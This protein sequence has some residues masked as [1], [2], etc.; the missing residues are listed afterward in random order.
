MPYKCLN[1]NCTNP[2][3]DKVF[4]HT[5][6]L[7]EF[8]SP[9]EYDTLESAACPFCRSKAYIE[10]EAVKPESGMEL[11]DII[12]L[13]EC[14]P[15]DVDTYLAQDYVVLQTWQKNVFVAKYK[16]KVSDL[17]EQPDQAGTE[18]TA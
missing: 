17:K 16:P 18:A 2:D 1:P 4:Q 10:I 9:N 11:K 3:P 6:K 7:L 12:S 8:L 5:A 13:K 14:A 15:N